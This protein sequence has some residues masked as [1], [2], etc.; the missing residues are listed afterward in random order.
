MNTQYFGPGIPTYINDGKGRDTYISF[1]N[2]GFGSYPFSKSYTKDSY[3]ISHKRKRPDLFMRRPIVKY[4]MDGIGRDYF[5]H[6]NILSEHCKLKEFSDFP[7]SL[8][9]GL[10]TKLIRL[11]KSNYRNKFEKKL[12]NRIFYGKCPGVKD[13]Q[14]SPK[15][16]F[17]K[18][19]D[20]IKSKDTSFDNESEKS[21]SFLETRNG[22]NLDLEDKK[23]NIHDISSHNDNENNVNNTQSKTGIE[24]NKNLYQLKKN[25]RK[26]RSEVE[27]N[28]NLVD[29]VKKI[30]LYNNFK[31]NNQ[32]HN[33][34]NIKKVDIKYNSRLR[35]S[36]S[37][38]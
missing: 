15:V 23:D 28:D 37:Q 13:R 9:N 36:L 33:N 1:Y 16:K 3:E 11:N 7:N 8:R 25:P 17:L 12:I 38:M 24:F 21:L 18:K 20:L 31:S 2:G 22:K 6:Q 19:N 26:Y 32:L 14:M 5:I 4:N 35:G 10:E 34:N 27:Q 29:S 30:F